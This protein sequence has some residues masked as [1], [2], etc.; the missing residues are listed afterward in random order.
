MARVLTKSRQSIE[1]ARKTPGAASRA[2]AARLLRDVRTGRRSLGGL[3]SGD[4]TGQSDADR[5]LLQE[6]VYG[7]LR[8]LVPLT[9]IADRLLDRP[10]KERDA[11]L[12]D[13]ILIGL[14]QLAF[15]QIPPHAVVS[16]TVEAARTIGKP[17]L[18]GL[19]N[20][21]LR[22]FLREQADLL[23]WVMRQPEAR[24]PYPAWLIEHLRTDWPDDWE[25]I[26]QASQGRAPMAVRVNPL[27]C[28]RADYL[29]TLAAAG[30]AARPI[31]ELPTGILLDQ[32]HLMRE[33]PGWERGWVSVQ[34]S[35]AQLAALLLAAPAGARVLDAC[36]APGGKT[37]AI[38]E[39]ARGELELI[40]MD[41]DPARLETAER[42]LK[43]LGLKAQLLVADAADPQGSWTE[44]PFD[45]ILL[46]VP[47]S[48]TGVMR[49]H[50]DIPWLRR[51][52]DIPALVATQARMLEAIWPLLRPGG[53]LLYATCSLFAQEN[54]VQVA[55]FVGRHPEA[56]VLLLCHPWGRPRPPGLQLLPRPG[57]HDGFF[58][59]LIAK[60]AS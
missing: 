47:C 32:P 56:Q 20:A 4:P 57:G 15:S 10:L 16:A 41:H 48:A 26:V 53:R 43:R 14:Y 54:E 51:P 45:R 30:I 12:Y 1:V 37:A 11:E 2:A 50:P 38:L 39:Q 7:S 33:L 27:R 42:L 55:D 13:L 58:Y 29:D 6:L 22:R 44:R 40:A 17:H 3:L 23:A 59:A 8:H 36:A 60:A 28:S 25:A 31:A 24:W 5:A 34:D 49:R 18:A 52:K 46:D 19:V 9:C 35:G 21:L